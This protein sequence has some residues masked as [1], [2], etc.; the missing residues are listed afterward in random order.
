MSRVSTLLNEPL[1]PPKMDYYSLL[2]LTGF[3]TQSSDAVKQQFRRM[4]FNHYARKYD[5]H[6]RNFSFLCR[7]GV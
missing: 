3:L 4:V 5:D 7:D 1:S 2:Q 6:A